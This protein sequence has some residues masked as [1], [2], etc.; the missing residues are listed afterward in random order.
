M[1][2]YGS[3]AEH[4][5]VAEHRPDLRRR[6]CRQSEGCPNL[7]RWALTCNGVVMAVGCE[8]CIRRRARENNRTRGHR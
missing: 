1:T 2:A 4:K 8:W 6:I 7:P 5:S 3:V